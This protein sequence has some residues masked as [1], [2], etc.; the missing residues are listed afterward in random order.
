MVNGTFSANAEIIGDVINIDTPVGA[1]ASEYIGAVTVSPL[2]H[3]PT[4]GLDLVLGPKLGFWVLTASAADSYQS[5]DLTVRGWTL[6]LNFGMFFPVTD[7][8]SLGM[9]L[10]Y[11]TLEPTHGCITRRGYGEVCGTADLTDAQLLGLSFAALF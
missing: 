8:T 6:G 9:L 5:I 3:F 4:P 10:S 11:A 2:F 7:T 1:S